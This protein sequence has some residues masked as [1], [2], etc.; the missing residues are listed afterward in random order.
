[1]SG[2]T[3]QARGAVVTGGGN[4]VGAAIAKAM[5]D[6]GYRVMIADIDQGAAQRVADCLDPSGATA[7]AQPLDVRG[8]SQFEAALK[9]ATAR[10][11]SVQALVNNAAMTVARPVMEI[12]PEEF[13]AVIAVNLRGTFLG[14]QVFGSYFRDRGH[15]RIINMASLA[16]QNGGTATGAHYAASKGGIVT[17]TKVFARDLGPSGVTV[18]AIAPGPIDSPMVHRTLTPER[19]AGLKATIPVGE[20]GDPAFIGQL[21]LQ[22]ASPAA[23]F[24]NGA[25]WD[26]N[27]G[28]YLR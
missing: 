17:L 2:G 1:M 16:G 26:V 6:G 7:F 8:K 25:T 11:G 21:V 13:D 10:W 24:A 15:G 12:S 14:C 27:G 19:L 20:I 23:A 5:H 9:V 28:L 4:G 22:L 18:N 3:E